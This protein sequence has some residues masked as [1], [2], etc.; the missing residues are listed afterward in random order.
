MLVARTSS[1]SKEDTSRLTNASQQPVTQPV[2][3]LICARLC[4]K[5]RS[6]YDLAIRLPQGGR[7]RTFETRTWWI[8]PRVFVGASYCVSD[9]GLP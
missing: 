2:L 7:C 4:G 3:T 9:G 8:A 5:P 6:G 1:F